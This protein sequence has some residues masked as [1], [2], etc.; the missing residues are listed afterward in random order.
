M[1]FYLKDKNAD[2]TPIFASISAP[3]RWKYYLGISVPPKAWD[4]AKQCV[5]PQHPNRIQINKVLDL[6]KKEIYDLW[7][8]LMDQRQ[9][10]TKD[11]I[12][13]RLDIALMRKEDTQNKL[14][15]FVDRFILQSR[16]QPNTVKMYRVCRK[17]LI[18]FRKD[19]TFDDIT[20]EFFYEFVSHLQKDY[21]PNTIW[22]TIKNLK[23]FMQD[24]LDRG[25]HTNKAFQHK[26]FSF[27]K[28]PTENMF[29]PVPE[30]EKLFNYRFESERLQNAADLF[31]VLCWT[32]VRVQD[33]TKVTK[34]NYRNLRGQECMLI[35]TT[36]TGAVVMIPMHPMLKAILNKYNF[37]LRFV[38][39]QKI[40]DY[41]KEAAKLAG[42]DAYAKLTTR[43]ARIS[44]ACNLYLSD[45]PEQTI[46]QI[47]GWNKTSTMM[48]YLNRL[49]KADH[50]E[51]VNKIWSNKKAYM[52]AI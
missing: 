11:Q 24:A 22:G 17:R 48:I 27:P 41:I 5:R 15:P 35:E 29:L 47:L 26:K 40:N 3:R 8:E 52:K 44:M 1:N 4:G 19:L 30:L 49:N 37:N 7:L 20:L 33:L 45:I 50:L 43:V 28:V 34:A 21:K 10:V 36:K 25:L 12:K 39:G 32:G 9:P 6:V 18:D 38:S 31:L 16:M 46:M 2:S 13:H 51:V 14:I 42:V 23:V